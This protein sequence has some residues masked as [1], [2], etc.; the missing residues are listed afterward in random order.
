[1][2]PTPVE[3][4]LFDHTCSNRFHG[5]YPVVVK[6][7]GNLLLVNLMHSKEVCFVDE[8]PLVPVRKLELSFG[9]HFYPRELLK[10]LGILKKEKSAAS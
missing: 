7:S 6:A 9:D 5:R 2:A 4:T 1:M 10:W 8:D 3:N